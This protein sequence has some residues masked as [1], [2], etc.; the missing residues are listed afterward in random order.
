MMRCLHRRLPLHMITKPTNSSSSE[1]RFA[2][3]YGRKFAT[4]ARQKEAVEVVKNV[5]RI[6]Q[7]MLLIVLREWL[8][9]RIN[10]W[11]NTFQWEGFKMNPAQ[12][13]KTTA[14]AY[15]DWLSGYM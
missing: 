1:D 5:T 8:N 2:R 6:K 3:V 7:D 10:S 15:A 9:P 12:I 11:G 4:F 14:K 13:E